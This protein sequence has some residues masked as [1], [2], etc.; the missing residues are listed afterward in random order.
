MKTKT[1]FC[2]IM[3]AVLLPL[4][5]WGG[6]PNGWLS[7]CFA[8]T[9][10]ARIKIVAKVQVQKNRVSLYDLCDPKVKMGPWQAIMEKVDIGEAP[11]VNSTKFISAARLRP[12]LQRFLRSHG[13]DPVKVTMTIPQQVTITRKAMQLTRQQVERIYKQFIWSKTPWDH[14]DLK[15]HR[16]YFPEL[17]ELPAGHLT[18]KVASA[19]KKTLL[20]NVSITIH[21]FVDG[22][23]ARTVRVMGAVDLYQ[24]V[25]VTVHP[26]SRHDIVR[27]SDIELVRT[28]V[29]AHPEEYATRSAQVVGEQLLC[30]IGPHQPILRHDLTRARVVKQ[31][32]LVT[33]IYQNRGLKLTAAGQA[34]QAGS[35]GE[36]IRVTNVM[37]KRT[38]LCQVVN[39]D[40][41]RTVP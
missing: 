16:I 12:Y 9:P 5:P 21:F 30:D 29:R 2:L 13:C 22:A 33:I 15:I 10:P 18:Y 1:A 8:L 6:L 39:S 3:G 37:T 32:S 38:I 28:N 26:L 23:S 31:G 4:L 19:P 14:K 17:P 40:T 41:V 25:A 11:S 34:R 36:T 27:A 20:G 7:I 35:I 24:K